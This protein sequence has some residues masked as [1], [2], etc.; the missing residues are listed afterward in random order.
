MRRFSPLLLALVLAGCG[1]SSEAELPVPHLVTEA[2]P[3]RTVLVG[4]DG[5]PDAGGPIRAGLLEGR[6]PRVATTAVVLTDTDCTPDFAG[7]S[8]CRN[9]LRLADGS[10]IAVRHHH[11]MQRY[12]CLSPGEKIRIV[13]G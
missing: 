10:T 6:M 4:K 2:A 5:A 1:G 13:P 3:L 9:E 7:I 12:S 8:H 11:D